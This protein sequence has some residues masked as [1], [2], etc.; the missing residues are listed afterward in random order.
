MVK[1]KKLVRDESKPSAKTKSV[2]SSKNLNKIG[3]KKSSSKSSSKTSGSS[4]DFESETESEISDYIPE[5]YVDELETTRRSIPKSDYGVSI[6]SNSKRKSSRMIYSPLPKLPN[7]R[8]SNAS[9]A[10]LKST[11]SNASTTSNSLKSLKS[12]VKRRVY[13]SKYLSTYAKP[14]SKEIPEIFDKNGKYRPVPQ[15][16]SPRKLR[17]SVKRRAARFQ[18][19]VLSPFVLY[20]IYSMIKRRK[21]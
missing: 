2:S 21:K 7:F 1:V 16:N 5:G 3:G 11:T 14:E 17:P 13:T 9:T 15:F 10:S 6:K 18:A 12:P 8:S 4:I 20:I 19:L